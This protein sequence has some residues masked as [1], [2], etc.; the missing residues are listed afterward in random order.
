MVPGVL[1]GSRKL[2]FH[3]QDSYVSYNEIHT[4]NRLSLN[5]KVI[6]KMIRTLV[7]LALTLTAGM[8]ESQSS[9]TAPKP[10]TAPPG[11]ASA[12]KKSPSSAAQS[13]SGPSESVITIDGL[14]SAPA[15]GRAPVAAPA[16]ANCKTVITKQQ[17]EDLLN[18]VN[19]NHQPI[20]A[21]QR[22]QLAQ[23]YVDLLIFADAARKAGIEKKPQFQ[24]AIRVQRMAV[25]QQVFLQD[26]EEQY[27]TPSA[28]EIEKFYKDNVS[29]FE[30]VKLHRIAIPKTN[31]AGQGDKEEFEKKAQQVANDTREQAAK[32]E[33][34]DKLQK[35]AYDSLG[36]TNPPGSTDFGKRK[37]GLFPPAEEQDIFA[38]QAGG[39]TKVE[40]GPAG[41]TIWKVDE[42]Q[43]IP[44]DQVREE[45]SRNLSQQK[46]RAKVDSIKA[47]VHP[48]FNKAYFAPPPTPGMPTG[49]PGAAVN[50]NS[51][52]SAPT[53]KA[54]TPGNAVPPPSAVPPGAPSTPPAGAP[55]SSNPSTPP[56]APATSP[57]TP[58]P[59]Q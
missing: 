9:S 15:A 48:D 19:P 40:T 22:Q 6:F 49:H 31:P 30:E 21:A 16:P 53:P 17:F 26:L 14:C 18:V 54:G 2:R 20:P 24:E 25:L 41:F 23:R 45:I 28:D 3:S 39:V 27:K 57:S 8:A 35:A 10:R 5:G 58:K 55:S 34:P 47:G 51:L 36:L 43:T 12:A 4:S 37:R 42:K 38:L 44:L 1:A 13:A 50:P 32:G 52:P 29:K 56:A 11:Q 46:M 33:D 59:P 7:V